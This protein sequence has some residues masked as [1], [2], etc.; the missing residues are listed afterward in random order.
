MAEPCKHLEWDS[1]FFGYRI[2]R[3]T[4]SNYEEDGFSQMLSWCADERIECLYLL[5]D[6]RDAQTVWLAE[7]HQFQFVDI[8][9]TL[10][11]KTDEQTQIQ[12]ADIR[13]HL[14]TDIPGL[15][16]IARVSH[17][18][19][20]FYY[21]QHFPRD[22]SDRLYETWIENSC[23]GYAEQVL[24][25]VNAEKPVGY[26]SCHLAGSEGQIGLLGVRA[27]AQGM[28]LGSKLIQAALSWFG[29]RGAGEVMVVTQGRNIAAQRIY[30]K[31]GFLTRSVQLWYHR[32]F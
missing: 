25:A 28:G 7:A 12:D 29:K 15:K 17:H 10:D 27:D 23:N 26:I 20:R 31:N 11:A 32:W 21:D 2:A 30:Q 1:K 9:L 4:L 22:L 5:A 8:R 3:A 13:P 24:V 19:T 18:D 14:T 16:A 6:S